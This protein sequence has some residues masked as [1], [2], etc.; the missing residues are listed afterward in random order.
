MVRKTNISNL[1]YFYIILSKSQD[2]FEKSIT[3]T[4]ENTEK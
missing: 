3:E 1:F 4:I 2:D